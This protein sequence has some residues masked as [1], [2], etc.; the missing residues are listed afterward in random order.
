ML[1]SVEEFPGGG[2][3]AEEVR[4]FQHKDFRAILGQHIGGDQTV[5]TRPDDD[6][7]IVGHADSFGGDPWTERTMSYLT[8][9]R[10]W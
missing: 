7:V 4:A 1:V 9:L 3:A 10:Q 6:R 2:H 5:V 8:Y